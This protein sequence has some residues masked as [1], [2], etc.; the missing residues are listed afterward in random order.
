[1]ASHSHSW[2]LLIFLILFFVGAISCVEVAVETGKDHT[3]KSFASGRPETILWKFQKT[4]VVEYEGGPVRWYRF[5]SRADLDTK[6]GD[7]T[8]KQ[9]NKE[10]SGHYQSEI[11]VDGKLQYS[12]HDIKVMDAVPV[13]NVTCEANSTVATLLCSVDSQFQAKLIW[14][15]P[16]GFKETRERIS[17]SFKEQSV[18]ICTAQ[19]ALNKAST[20]FSLQKCLTGGV[21]PVTAM[22]L[23]VSFIAVL[24]AALLALLYCSCWT[25]NTEL[26]TTFTKVEYTC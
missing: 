1:M 4:K 13:P 11:Q 23:T 21:S 20:E 2:D 22:S 19:N 7:F 8:L 25:G 14:T 10:D 6:T 16:N 26:D 12:D 15:G 24:I 5:I 18:Y 17:V 9:L 3:F